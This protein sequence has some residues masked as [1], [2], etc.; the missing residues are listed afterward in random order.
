MTNRNVPYGHGNYG[1]PR[2]AFPIITQVQIEVQSSGILSG[3]HFLQ[4]F[5][6]NLQVF[7]IVKIC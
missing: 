6:P 5:F 2:K 3:I 1:I 7:I 4:F